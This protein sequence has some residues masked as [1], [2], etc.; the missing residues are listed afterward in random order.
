[1][2]NGRPEPLLTVRDARN[3]DLTATVIS[4]LHFVGVTC[5]CIKLAPFRDGLLQYRSQVPD[6][7]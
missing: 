2:Y 7:V 5:A 6:N 3:H 1:M 4:V